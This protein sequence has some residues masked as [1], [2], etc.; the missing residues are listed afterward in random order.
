MIENR[1]MRRAISVGLVVAFALAVWFG[2]PGFEQASLALPSL[3]VPSH[4]ASVPK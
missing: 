4:R 2:P 3:A 1:A